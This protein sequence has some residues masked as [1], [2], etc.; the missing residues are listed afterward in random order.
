MQMIENLFFLF[1]HKELRRSNFITL[2]S[3]IK[4]FFVFQFTEYHYLKH[5]SKKHK[6][7]KVSRVDHELD[8][9]I[10]FIPSWAKHYG[11]FTAFWI[12]IAVHIAKVLSSTENV[13]KETAYN[14]CNNFILSFGRL[15]EFTREV[16]SQNLSTTKRPPYFGSVG[17]IAIHLFD[18][19]LLCIPSLHVLVVMYA[20]LQLK[21]IFT[22]YNIADSNINYIENAR[23]TALHISESI[24]YVKQHSINCIAASLYALTILDNK[25]FTEKESDDF[26]NNFFTDAELHSEINANTKKEIRA[27][28]GAVFYNFCKR[29]NELLKQN[30]NDWTAPLMEFLE[31]ALT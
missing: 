10:P 12:R 6:P 4:N 2:K 1:S 19:H 3:I 27:F 22:R 18:P 17:F 26:I 30:N 13:S 16:Y 24:L 20:Y 29:G 21:D 28:M 5:R 15:Y 7:L 9:A 31:Q 11:D 14:E 25:L 23:I 8:N